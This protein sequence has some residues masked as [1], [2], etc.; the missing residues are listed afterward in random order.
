MIK[1]KLYRNG[2]IYEGSKLLKKI[3]NGDVLD[4]L[5]ELPPLKREKFIRNEKLMMEAFEKEQKK[6]L[7]IREAMKSIGFDHTDDAE[8]IIDCRHSYT[9][10]EKIDGGEYLFACRHCLEFE[11]IKYAGKKI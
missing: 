6:G 2:D 7:S 1:L 11:Q 10:I 4:F 5:F 3:E 9:F 8:G